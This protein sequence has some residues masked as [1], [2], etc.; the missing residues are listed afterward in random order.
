MTSVEP[1][2][3]QYE[4]PSIQTVVTDGAKSSVQ[5]IGGCIRDQYSANNYLY[6]T[7]ISSEMQSTESLN[8]CGSIVTPIKNGLSKSKKVAK[9][10]NKV[11]F[12]FNY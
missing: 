4:S 8:L 7:P 3:L 6:Y 1:R 12:L 2:Y 9:R 10:L 11:S 5:S